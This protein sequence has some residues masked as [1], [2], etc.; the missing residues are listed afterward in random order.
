MAAGGFWTRHARTTTIAQLDARDVAI[1]EEV[2]AGRAEW[3]WQPFRVLTPDGH[4]LD[5]MVFRDALKIEGV[6]APVTATGAQEIADLVGAWLP[7]PTIADRAFAAAK[8]IAPQPMGDWMA[9]G[10]GASTDA[11]IEYSRR[12]DRAVAA[13]GG[14]WC[15]DVGKLWVLSNGLTRAHA[16]GPPGT[17]AQNYGWHVPSPTWG[18]IRAERDALGSGWVI[19]GPRSFRHDRGHVDYSQICWLVSQRG[20]LDGLDL[21]VR[22][23]A[24]GGDLSWLVTSEPLTIDRQPGVPPLEPLTAVGGWRGELERAPPPD[25]VTEE[26]RPAGDGSGLL[27]TALGLAAALAVAV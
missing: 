4:A 11:T 21:D 14:G 8:P 3:S 20:R 15:L 10:L 5:L 6:R 16:G 17:V 23:L 26:P 24:A 1:V 19:Q 18:G 22:H 13:A 27:V 2:R 9:A 7:T 12:V 25:D